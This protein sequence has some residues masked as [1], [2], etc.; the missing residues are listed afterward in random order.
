LNSF[1]TIL[2]IKSEYLFPRVQSIIQQTL[3]ILL[4]RLF[5]TILFSHYYLDNQWK[6]LGITIAGGN[7]HEDRLNQL[8]YP[9]GI[10]LDDNNQIIYIADCGND[11]IVE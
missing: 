11:R 2:S 9:N 4:L 6:Q 7:S 10:S 3:V 8:Y 5:S 1:Q